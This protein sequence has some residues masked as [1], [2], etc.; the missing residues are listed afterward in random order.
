MEATHQEL[1]ELGMKAHMEVLLL[2]NQGK[3]DSELYRILI[4]ACPWSSS[5][6]S[7]RRRWEEIARQTVDNGQPW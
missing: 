6:P 1:Y 7:A 4:E 3:P 5:Y 2:L